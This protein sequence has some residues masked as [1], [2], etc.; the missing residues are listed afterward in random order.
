MRWLN[1]I[2]FVNFFFYS[3]SRPTW[4][5]RKVWTAQN[6]SRHDTGSHKCKSRLLIFDS[7][8]QDFK[9]SV[10]MDLV[11]WLSFSHCC[12]AYGNWLIVCSAVVATVE[13]LQCCGGARHDSNFPKI[14]IF[15]LSFYRCAHSRSHCVHGNAA[16]SD[17]RRRRRQQCL[18]SLVH[19]TL[20]L[21]KY[22]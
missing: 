20:H 10:S 2:L 9:F 19:I 15:T 17:R 22:F 12:I 3:F 13:V 14:H 11:V 16:A 6:L 21:H 7:C 4:I 18:A 8:F 1:W 5:Q